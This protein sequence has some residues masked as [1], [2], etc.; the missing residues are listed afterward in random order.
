MLRLV[1]RLKD[2]VIEE[3]NLEKG[4]IQVGRSK[5]NDIVIDNVAIS[6]KHAQIERQEE[7][8]HVLRDLQSSNGTFLNGAKIGPQDCKLK[9]GDV[10]GL[11]KFEI[12][13]KGLTAPLQTAVQPLTPGDVEGTMIIDAARPKPGAEA[14]AIHPP[15]AFQ[16]P[17]LRALEGPHQGKEFKI[18]KEVTTFGNGI[19]DDIPVSGW[20]ISSPQARISRHGDRFYISHTGGFFSSTKVNGSGVKGDHILKNKDEIQVGDSAFVFT[21]FIKDPTG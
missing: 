19:Q 3:Y 12:L 10:I 15:K 2:A 1:L 9:E 6:R 5:E 8:G 13:V 7:K 20:F 21:Q 14:S 4:L 11:A 16:W 18:N 17:L